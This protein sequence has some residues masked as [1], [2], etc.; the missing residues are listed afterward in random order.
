MAD[1]LAADANGAGAGNKSDRPWRRRGCWPPHLNWGRRFAT[2]Q[3]A[4]GELWNEP[5]R[6]SL[7]LAEDAALTAIKADRCRDYF[8][9]IWA[10]RQGRSTSASGPVHDVLKEAAAT[11]PYWRGKDIYLLP[12]A[13]IAGE[14]RPTQPAILRP[15]RDYHGAAQP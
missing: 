4:S 10:C 2:I 3:V 6:P 14:C 1:A 5:A 13:L 11:A 8:A 9:L 15:T 7:N 12:L